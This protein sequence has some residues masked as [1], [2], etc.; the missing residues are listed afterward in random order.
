MKL[1]LF[2]L[3]QVGMIAYTCD[4][5]Q[6]WVEWKYVSLSKNLIWIGKRITATEHHGKPTDCSSPLDNWKIDHDELEPRLRTGLGWHSQNP[7]N[8]RLT[9]DEYLKKIRDNRRFGDD[10]MFNSTL[11]PGRPRSIG[12][13]HEKTMRGG[14]FPVGNGNT[15]YTRA[16]GSTDCRSI[17]NTYTRQ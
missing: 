5:A 2:M 16:D 15:C 6:S 1:K 14:N 3:F 4:D 8:Q 7:L 17:P 12:T 11:D 13:E 10:V 9:Y